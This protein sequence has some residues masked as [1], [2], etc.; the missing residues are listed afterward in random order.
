MCFEDDF[1]AKER[2]V[3]LPSGRSAV[4][5][6]CYDMFGV[7]EPSTQAGGRNPGHFRPVVMAFAAL[8]ESEKAAALFALLNPI[9]RTRARADMNRYKVEPYVVAAENYLGITE[10]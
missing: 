1:L 3:L 7:A 2:I 5:C 9:N 4:L 8:D 6:A 10:V